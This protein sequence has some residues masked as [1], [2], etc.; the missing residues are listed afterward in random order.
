MKLAGGKKMKKVLCIGIIALALVGQVFAG[1]GSKGPKKVH[2]V[3]VNAL[4]GHPVYEQQAVGARK[5]AEDYGINLEIIGPTMGTSALVEDTN[6]AIDQAI[7]LH[8]DAIITEPWDPSM[9][10]AVKRIYD[11]KIPNF[12]TSNLPDNENHFVSWIG[13]DLK[14]HGVMAAE[15]IAKKTGGKA[16]VCVMQS[17]LDITNQVT[18]RKAF[19]DTIKKY[20]NIKLVV[21]EADGADM[22]TAIKKFEEVFQ[23]YPSI[24]TVWML[25]ATGGPAAAQVAKERNKKVNILDVDA[26]DQTIDLIKKGE[27][28]GTLAQN[29]YKRGYE[30]VRMAYEYVTNGN[31]NSFEKYNDSGLVFIDQSNVNTYEKD[32]LDA[33][34]YKGTP[35]K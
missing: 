14:N 29:F 25:E 16:N 1:G 5:A 3:M 30:S 22:S 24:D 12:C 34:K 4:N 26:V 20:P 19:E 28:W 23:A 8:P 31:A 9:N 21:T 13:T 32:L 10:A 18:S 27:V 11:A 17:F 2:I 33:I 35:L 6:N 7:A 15:L